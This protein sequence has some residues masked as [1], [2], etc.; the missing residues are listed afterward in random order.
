MAPSATARR[1]AVRPAPRPASTP[2]RPPLQ[3]FEPAPR[4]KPTRR[5]VRRPTVW[6]AGLLVVGSLLAVVVGD[7]MISQGQVRLTATQGEIAAATTAQKALQV[8]VASIAA[9][10]VVVSQAESAGLVAP[11]QVVYLPRVPLNVPLP[12]PQLTAQ[13]PTSSAPPPTAATASTTA[14][15]GQ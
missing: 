14:T 15:A 13:P 12:V 9:P 4:P 3:V 11:T 8:E 2:S 1:G 6:V 7:A 5:S 10:P